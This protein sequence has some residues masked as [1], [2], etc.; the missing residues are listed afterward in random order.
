MGAS[1]RRTGRTRR[2]V[3]EGLLEDLLVHTRRTK[4]GT[5]VGIPATEVTATTETTTSMETAET[6]D[7]WGMAE[8]AELGRLYRSWTQKT[9]TRQCGSRRRMRCSTTCR[10]RRWRNARSGGQRGDHRGT[11]RGGV[12]GGVRGRSDRAGA[13]RRRRHRR[14]P[15]KH[16]QTHPQR[17]PPL[18]CTIDNPNTDSHNTGNRRSL[19]QK[20]EH[21]GRNGPPRSNT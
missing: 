6:A 21:G 17:R 18:V 1:R 12:R 5:E 2:R 15:P 13:K 10:N 9:R 8:M 11:V 16:P 19:T 3:L 20:M 14:Y 7:L 4:G